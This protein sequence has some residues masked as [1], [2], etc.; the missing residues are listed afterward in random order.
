MSVTCESYS[1]D[2]REHCKGQCD[3]CGGDPIMQLQGYPLCLSC[4]VKAIKVTAGVI[5]IEGNHDKTAKAAHRE[6]KAFFGVKPHAR[7]FR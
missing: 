5:A 3:A 6:L 2:V 4:A 7:R 1:S